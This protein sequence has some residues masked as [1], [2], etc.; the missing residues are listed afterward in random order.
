MVN[1]SKD[2]GGG[3]PTLRMGYIWSRESFWCRWKCGF[4]ALRK[5]HSPPPSPPPPPSS[6]ASGMSWLILWSLHTRLEMRETCFLPMGIHR[7]QRSPK[8]D[9]VSNIPR[10][11]APTSH[12]LNQWRARGPKPGIFT[13]LS[14]LVWMDQHITLESNGTLLDGLVGELYASLNNVA[15]TIPL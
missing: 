14:S 1:P 10:L 12:P 11:S 9:L 2:M 5:C 13:S 15:I 6:A 3:K 7:T 8:K 4:W